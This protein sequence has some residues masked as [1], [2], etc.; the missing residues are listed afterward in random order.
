MNINKSSWHYRLLNSL[1]DKIPT[2]LCPYFWK[3][4]W[5]L[6]MASGLTT[7]F[8][9]AMASIGLSVLKVFGITSGLVLVTSPLIGAVLI[10]IF[11]AIFVGV[12]ILYDHVKSSARIK[13]WKRD[14][15]KL[16][17]KANGEYKES[18]IVSFLKAKKE[19]LCP[20]LKFV[21]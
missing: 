12:A 6:V 15:K 5:A 19:K 21:D 2:S 9:S 17:E 16:E 7:L 18:L 4:V 10:A 11:V 1:F 20:S 8:I 3:T 13:K 14:A